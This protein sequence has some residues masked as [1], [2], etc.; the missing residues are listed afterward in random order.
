MNE[1]VATLYADIGV[2]VSSA[3]KG[4][5][6]FR[7]RLVSSQS[8]LKTLRDQAKITGTALNIGLT[9]GL[10][11]MGVKAVGALGDAGQS[12][13][14]FKLV[15]KAT[16]IEMTEASLAVAALAHDLT[17][18]SA[19]AAASAAALSELGKAGLSAKDSIAALRPAMLLAAAGGLEGADAAQILAN[20]LNAFKLPG[21]EAARIADLLA[22]AEVAAAGSIR[23]HSQA[24][25]QSMAV[26]ALAKQPVEDLVTSIGL[27]A[28]AGII[29]SDAG[30][31][32]RTMMLRLIAPTEEAV[33]L[34][35]SMGVNVYDSEGKVRSFRDVIE[36]FQ[37][38]LAPLTEAQ[39]NQR[40]E[41]IFGTDAVRAAAVIFGGGVEAYDAMKA[42]VTATGLAQELATAKTEGLKGSIEGLG[43]VIDTASTS[44]VKPFEG[45]IKT[46]TG[47]LADAVLWFDALDE[48]TK[49]LIV[50]FVAGVV[51]VGAV[52]VA[53][54]AASGVISTLVSGVGL[55]GGALAF[56]AANPVVAVIVILALLAGW[57]VHL[58]NTSE[59]FRT[60]VDSAFGAV[61]GAVS[62]MWN[63]VRPIFEAF[64]SALGGVLGLLGMMPTQVNLPSVLPPAQP[65]YGPGNRWSPPTAGPPAYG[66]PE[67]YGQRA[68]GGPVSA[69]RPYMVGEQGPELFVPGRGGNI[70]PSGGGTTV[71]ANFYGP[72]FGFADFK[73]QV[74]RAMNEAKKEQ[75]T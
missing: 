27:L 19:T 64:L 45:D 22:G 59:S 14:V 1:E 18:P 15:T 5:R 73:D 24:L 42:S 39:R 70:V 34:M 16:A 69:G 30:T 11:A 47:A 37:K 72:V 50:G 66:T 38:G 36:Q 65:N 9:A 4:L 58:Y 68:G 60:A 51:A 10:I 62:S 52:A 54:S 33:A 75:R 13:N 21:T 20:T 41:T 23:D 49:K 48:G 46:V 71:A 17:L 63:T 12:M 56:L 29:G 8:A 35:R 74:V 40:L 61:S 57:L 25:Q 32:L 26:W 28:N 6:D 31:S 67:Y 53:V 2:K 3:T 44:A 7:S 55:L 43:K